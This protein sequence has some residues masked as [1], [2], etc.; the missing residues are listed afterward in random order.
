MVHRKNK[1][2]DRDCPAFFP[3][4]LKFKKSE[5]SGNDNLQTHFWDSVFADIA[6]KMLTIII[7]VIRH[8]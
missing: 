6:L 4:L 8:T 5:Y 3:R 2:S 7:L 1:V